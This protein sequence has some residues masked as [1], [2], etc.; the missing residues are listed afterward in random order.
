MR[1]ALAA[2]AFSAAAV[3]AMSVALGGFRAGQ[4]SLFLVFAALA[5]SLDFVWG[6]AGILSL[7]QLLPFGI[8]AYASAKIA[9][10]APSLS[11][12]ALI[13][14]A[15]I[16]AAVAAGV[17]VAMLRRRPTAVVVGLLTLVLS[18]NA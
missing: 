12:G 13:V 17:G 2:G 4:L 5:V 16:G 3:A 15:C 8:A 18:L 7:G 6:Y 14:A 1:R 11:V 10:A 9:L